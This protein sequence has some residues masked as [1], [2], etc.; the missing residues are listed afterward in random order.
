MKSNQ[1]SCQDFPS[2]FGP[3]SGLGGRTGRDKTP[4]P[5]HNPYRK[6]GAP[7]KQ[8][9]GVYKL[10]VRFL[11]EETRVRVLRP[12][13]V[14]VG[15]LRHGS[16]FVDAASFLCQVILATVETNLRLCA[17]Y[18]TR[19]A[20]RRKTNSHNSWMQLASRLFLNVHPGVSFLLFH[21][22]Y[23]GNISLMHARG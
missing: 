7:H 20:V 23:R 14:L 9:L 22:V 6:S 2:F 3:P 19:C 17:F 21:Q 13:N 15:T 1:A 8:I 16:V 11:I 18:Q 4:L 10:G 12:G 5:S